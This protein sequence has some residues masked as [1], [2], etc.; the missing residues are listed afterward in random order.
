M[1]FIRV[2]VIE[3]EEF[4]RYHTNLKLFFEAY[5]PLNRDSKAAT[6]TSQADRLSIL[7]LPET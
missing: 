3:V 2:Y 5:H 7:S 1:P 6:A 4:V